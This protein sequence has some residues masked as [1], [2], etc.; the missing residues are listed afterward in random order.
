MSL[1]GKNILILGGIHGKN[2]RSVRQASAIRQ[3]HLYAHNV[4]LRL[5]YPNLRTIRTVIDGT[6][7]RI[8]ICMK[9][10]KAMSKT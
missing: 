9:C 7:R 1:N 2:L 3:D 6:S 10:L 8:K 5:Y 4:N